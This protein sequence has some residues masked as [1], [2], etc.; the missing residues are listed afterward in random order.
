MPKGR[1]KGDGRGRMGGRKAG[2][3]NKINAELRQL[4]KDFTVEGFE[5][6]KASFKKIDDPYK[7]CDIYLKVTSFV[8]PKLAAVDLKADVSRKSFADELDEMSK[9]QPIIDDKN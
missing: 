5:E 6:F 3:P 4:M 7:K 8:T 1:V 2:T 9:E